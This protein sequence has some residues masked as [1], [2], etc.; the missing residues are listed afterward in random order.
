MSPNST[1]EHSGVEARQDESRREALRQFGR[2]AAVAPT[3]MLLLRPGLA[4]AADEYTPDW[5]PGPPPT[6]PPPNSDGRPR[7]RR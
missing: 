3:T 2:Y 4:S 7:G 1:A 6:V 5:V